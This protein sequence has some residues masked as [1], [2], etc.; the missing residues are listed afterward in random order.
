M[1]IGKYIP[2]NARQIRYIHPQY[3]RDEDD[4]EYIWNEDEMTDVC[5]LI[6]TVNK[7]KTPI[8]FRRRH[9]NYA[10]EDTRRWNQFINNHNARSK[11]NEFSDYLYVRVKKVGRRVLIVYDKDYWDKIIQ[12][13]KKIRSGLNITFNPRTTSHMLHRRN[14]A[15]HDRLRA[16]MD[17]MINEAVDR[18]AEERNYEWYTTEEDRYEEDY[19]ER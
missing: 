13:G 3:E 15:E 4:N 5:D 17:R 1:I 9:S 10:R 8:Y 6:Y 7:H 16:D 14:A 2:E 19:E 18:V 11:V 12:S